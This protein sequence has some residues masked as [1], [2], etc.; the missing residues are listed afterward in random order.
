M[1]NDLYINMGN[2]DICLNCNNYVYDTQLFPQVLTEQPI[3]LHNQTQQVD[4]E[5]RNLELYREWKRN[6]RKWTAC[7]VLVLVILLYLF[8]YFVLYRNI[9]RM[10]EPYFFHYST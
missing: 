4:R 8:F 6:C 9:K 5:L 10:G 3:V 2:N 1:N 7:F